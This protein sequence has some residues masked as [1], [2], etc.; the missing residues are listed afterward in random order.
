MKRDLSSTATTAGASN[1]TGSAPRD[2]L[3]DQV[4]DALQTES[5]L[6]EKQEAR[7]DEYV[8]EF[9]LL[10]Q[11]SQV[12]SID[13]VKAGAENAA[14]VFSWGLSS[15]SDFFSHATEN[16]K[17]NEMVKTASSKFSQAVDASKPTVNAINDSVKPLV[18]QV[19]SSLA[20]A[21]S[22]ATESFH[23]LVNSASSATSGMTTTGST[24]NNNKGQNNEGSAV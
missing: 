16:A 10:D 19:S 1:S 5:E 4:P 14:Q 8:P 24:N 2:S 11:M 9:P 23:Q 21:S 3:D 6:D 18:H 12:L 17:E 22:L 15:V 20:V 13:Q 7:D